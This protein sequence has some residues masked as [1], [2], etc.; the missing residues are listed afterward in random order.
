[1]SPH[2]DTH[3]WDWN[4][5]RCTRCF[6]ERYLVEDSV[7]PLTCMAVGD[8][9]EHVMSPFTDRCMF[10][11]VSAAK[12]ARFGGTCRPKQPTVEP[13]S[14]DRG[15]TVATAI[16]RRASYDHRLGFSETSRERDGVLA[17]ALATL[18]PETGARSLQGAAESRTPGNVRVRLAPEGDWRSD[19]LVARDVRVVVA[20]GSVPVIL[21]GFDMHGN[22]ATEQVHLPPGVTIDDV[23][24]VLG[25]PALTKHSGDPLLSVVDPI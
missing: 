13:V 23:R 1:M 11:G 16:S 18:G 17:P 19:R 6:T 25:L 7:V 2:V 14:D 4:L 10:C 5:A 24:H 22:P 8:A 15:Q 21:G 3:T 20:P 9:V 12:L